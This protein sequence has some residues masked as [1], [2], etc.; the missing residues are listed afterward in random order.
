MSLNGVNVTNVG[1][2]TFC[3]VQMELPKRPYIS[4]TMKVIFFYLIFFICNV[5]FLQNSNA[6]T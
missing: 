2:W 4:D 6:K 3:S 5:S 1:K